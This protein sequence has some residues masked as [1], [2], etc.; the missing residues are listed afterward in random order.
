MRKLIVSNMQSLDGYY[1]GAD[2]SLSELFRYQHPA[3]AADDALDEYHA[4]LLRQ[5]GVLLLAGRASFLDNMRYWQSVQ[6]DPAATAIRQELAILMLGIE[7]LVVSDTLLPAEAAR[8]ANTRVVARVE[9]PAEV[10]WL[11]Q[12]P[13]GPLLVLL[14]RLLWNNLLLD[15]LVDELHITIAP[16]VGGVGTPVFVGRPKV[17]LRLLRAQTFAGSGN[18][19]AVYQPKR[20]D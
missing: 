20:L 4:S 19:L 16:L 2:G 10:A 3:Y 6:A 17:A 14:S 18:I 8:F 13:G 1:Q 15:G 11:K 9:A 7:K 5:A 12:Q